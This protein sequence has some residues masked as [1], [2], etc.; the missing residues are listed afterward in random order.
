MHIAAAVGTP[1][2]GLFGPSRPEIWFPYSVEKGHMALRPSGI[3]CC[4]RDFCVHPSPC[5][6]RITVEQALAAVERAMRVKLY[7]DCSGE[8]GL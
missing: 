5:I 1:T 8:A 3:E 4:G 6:Y 7:S 2:I